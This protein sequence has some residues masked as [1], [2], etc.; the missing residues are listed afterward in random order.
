[1]PLTLQLSSLVLLALFWAL[2]AQPVNSFANFMG[3]K[4]QDGVHKSN[5]YDQYFPDCNAKK[6][7]ETKSKL[8]VRNS[9]TQCLPERE[10]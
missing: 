8:K 1:M 10:S 2:T 7:L 3:I 9:T 5:P 4:K 6:R